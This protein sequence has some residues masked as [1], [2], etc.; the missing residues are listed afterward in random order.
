MADGYLLDAEYGALSV[1]HQR[2]A[3]II[4]DYNPELEL[5]FIPAK[6]RTAFDAEPFAVMHNMPNGHRY[7]VM[8]CKEE[9]VDHRLL[10]RLWSMNTANNDVLSKIEAEE[11]AMRAVRLKEQMDE[12]EERQDFV[13]TAIKG[14]HYFRHN[15]KVY[16]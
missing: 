16:Q 10:A 1:K 7:L 8:T 14:K 2:I 13:K 9:E 4:H 6:D 12:A 3:E 5:A 11:A 15:G